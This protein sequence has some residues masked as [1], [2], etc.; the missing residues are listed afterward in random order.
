[1]S[2]IAIGII[3]AQRGFM[4]AEEGSRLGVQGFGE[5]AV[6]DGAAI[7]PAVNE[8]LR[9]ADEKGVETFVTK[10]FHPHETAHFGEDPDFKDTWPVHCVAGTPG[11]ELHPGIVLSGGTT[12]FHKGTVALRSGEDDRSYSGFTGRDANGK[13]LGDYLRERGVTRLMLGGLAFGVCVGETG[14][15]GV[16]EGFDVAIVREA[17]RGLG[18]ESDRA[19]QERLDRYGVRVI[20][21]AEALAE[22]A[23]A[24]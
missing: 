22:L 18:E 19:M 3:D 17:T 7:V 16:G 8:L 14:L 23:L 15:D 5:L 12:E 9:V 6:A 24:K 10:D 1:M 20:S 21:M 2:E 11:S 13:L 4:P